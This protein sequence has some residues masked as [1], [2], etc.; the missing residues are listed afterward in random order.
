MMVFYVQKLH[1][2]HYK[3]PQHTCFDPPMW[4][5]NQT[6]KVLGW[7]F[8][9]LVDYGHCS[10]PCKGPWGFIKRYDLQMQYKVLC[11]SALSSISTKAKVGNIECSFVRGWRDVAQVC[12]HPRSHPPDPR[13]LVMCDLPTLFTNGCSSL[14]GPDVC[15]TAGSQGPWVL[16]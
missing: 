14:S 11:H 7:P 6:V 2:S 12:N 13:D 15:R 4:N 1:Y 16:H 8:R 5:V 3:Y 9:F 10:C